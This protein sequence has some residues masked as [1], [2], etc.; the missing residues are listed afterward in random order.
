MNQ[1]PVSAWTKFETVHIG[2]FSIATASRDA[3][4][5]AMVSDCLAAR[6]AAFG[7]RARVIVDANGHALSLRQ[8]D[9]AYRAAV[10]QADV[11][12]ADGG[13]LVTVS[14]LRTNTPIAERS[15]TTDLIHD[16]ARDAVKHG[17]SFYL[18]GG[19]ES[20]NAECAARLAVAHPGLKIAGRRHG[21]FAPEEEDEVVDSINASSADIVWIGLGKPKEQIF[22]VQHRSRLRAGWLVTCGGCF[23]YIAGSYRRAPEWMQRNNLEWL[24]RMASEPKALFW[25]YLLT[26]PHALLLALSRTAGV[27]PRLSSVTERW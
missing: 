1:Q 23:N 17:L 15:A 7:E 20:I 27:S 3:L 25:R 19:S 18:L 21:F 24:H 16:C 26:T 22:A 13:F 9:A 2:G 6:N 5:R 4:A 11:V 12:H 14:R 8:T 10:D